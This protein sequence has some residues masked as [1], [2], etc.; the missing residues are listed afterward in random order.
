MENQKEST[1][2]I[3]NN[4]N[5]LKHSHEKAQKELRQDTELQV[6]RVEEEKRELMSL[7][8]TERS[9]GKTLHNDYKS[10]YEKLENE[11]GKLQKEVES[12][13]IPIMKNKHEMVV[14][15][16]EE[17]IERL[18]LATGTLEVEHRSAKL[19]LWYAE[20]GMQNEFI[21]RAR[22]ILDRA[23]QLFHDVFMEE[24]SGDVTKC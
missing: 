19:W 3:E 1:I 10:R 9:E 2:D 6:A 4:F 20:F 16:K 22:N 17:T 5:E 8:E 11:V 14:K 21:S 15:E 24:I 12:Y 13:D 18:K 23:V 7:F